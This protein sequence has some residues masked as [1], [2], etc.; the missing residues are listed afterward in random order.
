MVNAEFSDQAVDL[1]E[2]EG[3]PT[4]L[5]LTLV[6]ESPICAA[7]EVSSLVNSAG[8]FFS[9]YPQFLKRYLT[10]RIDLDDV[11]LEL[12]RQFEVFV[13][14]GLNPLFVNSH[15]HV[16]L[17]PGI[18]GRVLQLC[19]EFDVPYVRTVD[20]LLFPERWGYLDFSVFGVKLLSK[21]TKRM[22]AGNRMQTN[23]W[24]SGVYLVETPDRNGWQALAR[25]LPGGLT[26]IGL[27]LA[28][29]DLHDVPGMDGARGH[30]SMLEAVC[31]KWWQTIWEEAGITVESLTDPGK[32]GE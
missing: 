6:Q 17:L 22:L 28:S 27:H 10:G 24:F 13:A 8:A 23:D 20:E 12:R 11:E 25:H 21:W 18:F 29:G 30:V 32:L 5:H 16:H 19:D 4:G 31:S 14:S 1:A 7:S 15:E 9:H 2:S 3:I 26:E